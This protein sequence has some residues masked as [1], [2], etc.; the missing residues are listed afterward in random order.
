M[1]GAP[2][3]ERGDSNLS[4]PSLGGWGKATKRLRAGFSPAQGF[5]LVARRSSLPSPALRS[6]PPP[7]PLPPRRMPASASLRMLPTARHPFLCPLVPSGPWEL[8]GAGLGW[9]P[10]SPR[11]RAEAAPRRAPWS[12]RG[13]HRGLGTSTR[14]RTS[15]GMDQDPPH[16]GTNP[17]ALQLHPELC[18]RARSKRPPSAPQPRRGP[19]SRFFFFGRGRL[20][21]KELVPVSRDES[22]PRWARRRAAPGQDGCL[23]TAVLGV[24]VSHRTHGAR[25][26][27]SP[28]ATGWE[29][30]CCPQE[31]PEAPAPFVSL[32]ARS[33]ERFRR[34]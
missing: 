19:A 14:Q 6:L 24:L 31:T 21:A 29:D 32:I 30:H 33:R 15:C 22:A 1:S 34:G 26:A 8:R 17:G 20:E 10:P 4:R 5:P 12:K 3:A 13:L 16:L 11:P 25:T 9:A 23:L 18:S 28:R 2:G 27:A 7:A